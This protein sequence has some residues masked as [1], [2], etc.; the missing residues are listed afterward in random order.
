M[1]LVVRVKVV[2]GGGARTR[3]ARVK[4][5]KELG[6]YGQVV[7]LVA[8]VHVVSSA[9]EVRGHRAYGR[10]VQTEL[11]APHARSLLNDEGKWDWMKKKKRKIS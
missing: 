11:R 4:W 9:R 6:P 1:V 2:R 5:G 3:I 10:A 7:A 8:V